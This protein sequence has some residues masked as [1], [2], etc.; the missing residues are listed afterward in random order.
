MAHIAKEQAAT[1][2]ALV[3]HWL[4]SFLNDRHGIVIYWVVA[5]CIAPFFLV[6]VGGVGHGWLLC[7][8]VFVQT[9]YFSFERFDAIK[10]GVECN[11]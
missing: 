1:L 11:A 4:Q 10:C 6:V 9:L 8:G 5:L 7:I 3:L 2:R